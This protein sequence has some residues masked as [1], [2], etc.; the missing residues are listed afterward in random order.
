MCVV[1]IGIVEVRYGGGNFLNLV[2]MG[3][4]ENCKN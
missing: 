3:F 4:F 2:K 1:K